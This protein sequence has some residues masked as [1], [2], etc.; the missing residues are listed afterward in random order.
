MGD[1][2]IAGARRGREAP[3]LKA[4]AAISQMDAAALIGCGSS[5]RSRA[6]EP[7][8]RYVGKV[9]RIDARLITRQL[10]PCC[11]QRPQE[12][13]LRSQLPRACCPAIL[14]GGQ[15]ARGT[16]DLRAISYEHSTE[17]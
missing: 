1:E 5:S 8:G 13:G 7:R 15:Q 17:H 9:Y 14:I 16:C 2:S 12:M 4:W 10:N 11:V 3:P 6:R